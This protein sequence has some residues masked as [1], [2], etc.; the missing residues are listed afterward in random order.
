MSDVDNLEQTVEKNPQEKHLSD[1]RPSDYT[2]DTIDLE[3]DLFDDQTTVKAV[4]QL[5]RV[6]KTVT[7]LFL[8][9]EDLS[10]S[11]ILVDGENHTD[12]ELVE[13]GLIIKQ[14]T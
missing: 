2:V 6:S 12:Y 10:L 7:P 14:F 13:G 11:S 4:S 3:F 5:H 8:F 1:Y 9:G